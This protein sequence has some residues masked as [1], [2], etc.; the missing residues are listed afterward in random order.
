[1]FIFDVLFI[2]TAQSVLLFSIT[3]PTYI[4]LLASR[5]T[6]LQM[7]TTDIVIARLLMACVLFEFFA[8]QQQWDF[9][10][11]KNQ[12]QSTAKVPPKYTRAEMDRGFGTSGLWRYSRHPNFLAE[13][14]IW[15]LLYQWCCYETN[16]LFNYA[17]VGAA[18][19]LILFQ[20]STWLT[21]KI[22]A[23]KYPEYKEYQQRVGKFLPKLSGH[24][25]DE[26][27]E[28]QE[29]KKKAK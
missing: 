4:L 25:W 3:T 26:Y 24:A 13:Q 17:A 29:K 11:A 27:V 23:G 12:Y 19:Y 5:L 14:T 2:S 21:E 8:D 15:V 28:A 18:S 20:S 16:T 1:M 22:S 10:Q 7:Q 6:G 9:H